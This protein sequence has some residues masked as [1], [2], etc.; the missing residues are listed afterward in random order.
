[1]K[2]DYGRCFG[3]KLT[4]I[5]VVLGIF[6]LVLSVLDLLE[7]RQ[8]LLHYILVVKLNSPYN[9]YNSIPSSNSLQIFY[10]QFWYQIIN[11]EGVLDESWPIMFRMK[12]DRYKRCVGN[13]SSRSVSI[14]SIRNKT[15]SFTL[16]FGSKTKQP[17]KFI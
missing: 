17:T 14:E 15:M 7:I 2:V 4:G 5:N 1:M 8:C 10:W 11:M 12:V 6:L 9:S 3:W 16:Y 13:F